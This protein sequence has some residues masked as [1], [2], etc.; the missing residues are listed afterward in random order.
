MTNAVRH[1]RLRQTIGTTALATA[2]TCAAT[3]H[4]QTAPPTTPS[5]APNAEQAS[6]SGLSEI[7]VT[8]RKR[9][10]SAQSVPVAVTAISAATIQQRDL[11]SLEKIAAAT[12][13]F[14]VG[15]ASNGSGA[16][17]T[18]RGIGSSS[19]SIGIEQSVA[20]VVDG[21]Y[22]GQGRIINEGFF[23]LA[24]VEILKGP[25]AL[26]F[27]KNATAGVISLSTADPG[28][29]PELIARA[30]YEF[31]SHQ[32]QGEL[33]G[34]TPLTDT[35]GIRVAFRGSKM[36]DGYYKNV[37]TPLTYPTFDIA[38][39]VVTPH[40]AQPAPYREPAEKE[41]LGRI[42]L[43]WTPTDAITD[44]VKISGD[45]NKVNNNSWNYVAFHCVGGVSHLDGYACGDHFITHQN[46]IPVDMAANFPFAKSDGSLYD[47]Y[48]SYAVTNTF[49][50]KLPNVTLT[51]VT[52]YNWNNNR[53]ACACDFQSSS[54]AT[55]ATENSTWH[56]FSNEAR[57]QTTFDSPINLMAGI[58]Y[59]K[60]KRTFAQFITF[61][62]I[63]D[64]SQSAANRYLAT[65][66]TS[67][68][69]G[70]TVAGF[71]QV[72]W[73][74]IPTIEA[75]AGVRYTH[76]TKDSFFAQPYNNAALTA[77]FRPANS[78]DGLGIVTANQVFNDWSPEAT[79]SWKPTHDIMVYG[80][81]KTNY[82]SGG[83]SNGGINSGFSSNPLG[84]LT[85]NPGK[86]ARLR[87]RHQV[88]DLR[89]PAAPEPRPLHLWLQEPAG[90]LLQF[91]DLRVPNAHRRRTD[92]GRRVGVRI[93]AACD[94]RAQRP[95]LRQLQ[96][97]TLH[98]LPAGTLLCR[99]NARRGLQPRVQRGGRQLHAPEPDW[100]AA[101][102][103][104]ALDGHFGAQLHDAVQWRAAL[105]C[106]G[107]CALQLTL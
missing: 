26:F 100:Q 69:N 13:E 58:Y 2:L 79:I 106:R 81:Y 45:Y 66:K 99:R 55:W 96:Q 74:I 37:S 22:Y 98:Q 83:F 18:L 7:I 75:T 9:V 60:T 56:A 8:A 97:G 4:A 65:T 41:Y 38:T 71:G 86:G 57:A 82:K 17:L 62:N 32:V 46:K 42:T 95:R 20:T 59:Q 53:W 33:I 78:P 102:G 3:A 80:A 70:E 52:N 103:R 5:A 19:T 91:A 93:C 44:T 61:A 12:P 29:K 89:Q 24:R 43:K 27:G 23:D 63:E 28:S 88:D 14:T 72:S 11:T 40:T 67:F 16:Q 104:P 50:Y 76:E 6:P 51:N 105:R 107:R 10:E 36:W 39:G 68:T 94:P 90:R 35:L 1:R 15:R 49:T 73:K 34:S 85:F 64:S 87:G 30:N 101:F 84:D 48:K 31:R 25:Q 92:Q 77:I 54:A 47:R 21:V